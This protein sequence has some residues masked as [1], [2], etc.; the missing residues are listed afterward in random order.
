MDLAKKR[1]GE[2]AGGSEE[3]SSDSALP[4]RALG[5]TEETADQLFHVD[6]ST[7]LN[8]L[9]PK[10]MWLKKPRSFHFSTRLQEN[11]AKCMMP[12]RRLHKFILWGFVCACY[13]APNV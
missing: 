2:T 9:E 3:A 6:V 12:S 8:L 5:G 10:R 4:S 13:W 1:G 7:L 11:T